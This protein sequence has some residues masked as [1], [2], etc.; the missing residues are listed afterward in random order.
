MNS[1]KLFLNVLAT[2]MKILQK[3]AIENIFYIKK[4]RD[5]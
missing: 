4:N 5:W 2:I 3:N 1:K